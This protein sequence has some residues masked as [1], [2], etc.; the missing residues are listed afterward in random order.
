M[1][2]VLPW[3]ETWFNQDLISS[4]IFSC[5]SPSRSSLRSIAQVHYDPR[6]QYEQKTCSPRPDRKSNKVMVVSVFAQR[7]LGF[8]YNAV[9][10]HYACSAF[11]QK[12][13][14]SYHR[15]RWTENNPNLKPYSLCFVSQKGKNS[16]LFFV[17][18]NYDF[19]TPLGPLGM[20]PYRFEKIVFLWVWP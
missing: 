4:V 5:R 13:L 6:N 17:K 1:K 11:L 12:K 16:T 3:I 2:I 8:L 9:L 18:T 15:G 10:R 19:L 7:I 14:K 20:R